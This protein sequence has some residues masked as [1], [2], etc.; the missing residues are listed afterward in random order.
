MWICIRKTVITQDNTTKLFF[1]LSC[2]I[3]ETHWRVSVHAFCFLA[4]FSSLHSFLDD[5]E[6]YMGTLHIYR[7]S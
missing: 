3:F 2:G 7:M 1:P 4:I 6:M 5:T